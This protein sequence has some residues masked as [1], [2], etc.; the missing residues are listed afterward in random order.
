VARRI[1]P[2]F[3]LLA[4]GPVLVVVHG[5]AKDTAQHQN[6]EDAEDDKDNQRRYCYAQTAISSRTYEGRVGE[7]R[8]SFG[9]FT[10]KAAGRARE[11]V[12]RNG[13]ASLF[14]SRQEAGCKDLAKYSLA[15]VQS[16]VETT[17]ARPNTPMFASPKRL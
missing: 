13:D 17:I 2:S 15:F 6:R 4:P 1:P 14:F 12:T 9:K 8:R 11:A 16:L 7:G 10:S 5:R 3:V